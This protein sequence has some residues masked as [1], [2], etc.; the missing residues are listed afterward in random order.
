[1]YGGE[2]EF[3]GVPLRMHVASGISPLQL[4]N[5]A[6]KK[7]FLLD[8]LILEQDGGFRRP[9]ESEKL[10]PRRG[11]DLRWRMDSER[12]CVVIDFFQNGA[13]L[14]WRYDELR[15][16]QVG[17]SLLHLSCVG[18]AGRFCFEYQ[19]RMLENPA[20]DTSTASER[21]LF[22]KSSSVQNHHA[23][24]E[25]QIRRSFYRSQCADL[26][27]LQGWQGVVLQTDETGDVLIDFG[28]D[29]GARWLRRRHV[30]RG[31][32][33]RDSIEALVGG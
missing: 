9:G 7:I 17:A 10:F 24:D 8:N 11:V 3:V 14:P 5:K 2:F 32:E 33:R 13:L 18:H 15:P 26:Q 31:L 16:S 1:V 25:V 12:D 27:V 6:A 30:S 29:L 20:E 28:V 19:L 23:G 22:G 21:P 4:M